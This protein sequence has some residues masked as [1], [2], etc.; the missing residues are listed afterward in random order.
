MKNI[1]VRMRGGL[2]NQLFI[3]AYALYLQTLFE[4]SNLICD[5]REYLY[6][7][8]R[9]Y[10]LD[11]MKVG[12]LLNEYIPE[13]DRHNFKYEFFMK[14][15]HLRMYVIKKMHLP[16][17]EKST[18]EEKFQIIYNTSDIDITKF[19]SNYLYLYGYF[20]NVKPLLKIRN[21]LCAYFEVKNVSDTMKRYLDMINNSEHSVAISMRFGQDYVDNKWPICS[22]EYYEAGIDALSGHN[23]TIFVFADEID[24]AKEYFKDRNDVYFIEDCSPTEQMSIMKE[25]DD[26]IIS[27]STFS[28]WG[29]FLG[30][31]DNRVIYAPDIWHDKKTKDSNFYYDNIQV[32]STTGEFL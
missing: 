28:W 13:N 16:F 14:I 25:C 26:Y 20:V 4:K 11:K 19:K 22:K 32:I 30:K 3:V 12:E 9:E 29:A 21:K 6:Y 7:K 31:N 2:G 5:T 10:E 27:N 8:V 15:L 17:I 1:V 23:T 24:K 18:W